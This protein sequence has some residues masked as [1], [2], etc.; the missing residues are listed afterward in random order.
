MF[1]LISSAVTVRA[2]DA[3]LALLSAK[4]YLLLY[5]SPR[6]SATAGASYQRSSIRLDSRPFPNRRD[7]VNE[8]G[9]RRPKVIGPVLSKYCTIQISHVPVP[10]IGRFE[11]EAERLASY[12][13]KKQLAAEPPRACTSRIEISR[14]LG[15][16]G[17]VGHTT[18]ALLDAPAFLVTGAFGSILLLIGAKRKRF[19]S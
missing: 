4:P 7:A 12:R 2:T 15:S 14:R 13:G 1:G 16:S 8:G 9:A 10:T 5:F 17:C 6:C 19:R 11:C 18:A 3:W